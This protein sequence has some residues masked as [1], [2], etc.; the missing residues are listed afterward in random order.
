MLFRHGRN[1][2]RR[3]QRMI[4]L[5]QHFHALQKH[6]LQPLRKLHG[7][8]AKWLGALKRLLWWRLGL[9]DSQLPEFDLYPQQSVSQQVEVLVF[10]TRSE[11]HTS[12]L[13]SRE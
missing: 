13:Q 5:N 12:E 7:I 8:Q 6:K 11:E 4:V 1:P 2:G 9:P 10:V 3:R